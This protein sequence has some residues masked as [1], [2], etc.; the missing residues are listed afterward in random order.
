MQFKTKVLQNTIKHGF[1]AVRHLIH[2]Q[3]VPYD[4][5][6][7]ISVVPEPVCALNIYWLFHNFNPYCHGKEFNGLPELYSGWLACLNTSR[8]IQDPASQRLTW[9][10]PPKS[11]LVIKK[12]R[13]ASL[14]Q[15]FKELCIF[16]TEVR[17]NVEFRSTLT[18]SRAH[19][20]HGGAACYVQFVP[21][22]Q[23]AKLQY[24]YQGCRGRMV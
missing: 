6:K 3:L 18:V 2:F 20:P 17:P 10:K 21:P 12:I 14:L 4:N 24:L 16:L 5:W 22:S 15:P 23:H 8:H 13:D 7:L 9:N 1:I 19:S 11:V